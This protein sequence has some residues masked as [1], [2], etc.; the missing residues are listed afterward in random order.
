MNDMMVIF[1]GQMCRLA[2]NVAQW[3]AG[4]RWF[5]LWQKSWP[6]QLCCL[7]ILCFSIRAKWVRTSE[8]VDFI[9]FHPW[10]FSFFSPH[11]SLSSSFVSLCVLL[12][13]SCSLRLSLDKNIARHRAADGFCSTTPTLGLACGSQTWGDS[14]ASACAYISPVPLYAITFTYPSL[15]RYVVNHTVRQ[16]LTPRCL[17]LVQSGRKLSPL[18]R[19]VSMLRMKVAERSLSYCQCLYHYPWSDYWAATV[20]LQYVM[21]RSVK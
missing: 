13:V 10:S 6:S 4:W 21:C 15:L 12:S 14:M 3:V 2:P 17:F 16:T 18:F 20:H 8:S 5:A 7:T 9:Y 19:D 1:K 11:R